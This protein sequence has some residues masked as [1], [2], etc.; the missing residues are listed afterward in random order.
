MLRQEVDLPPV[1]AVVLEGVEIIPC[2]DKRLHGRSQRR[3]KAKVCPHLC[4][5]SIFPISFSLS[6]VLTR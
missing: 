1:E 6:P 2:N 5:S 4:L 3:N